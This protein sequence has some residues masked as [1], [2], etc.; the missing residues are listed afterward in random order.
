MGAP[1]PAGDRRRGPSG[2]LLRYAAR[3]KRKRR[4]LATALR[5]ATPALPR[6]PPPREP[7]FILGSPRSGTTS[8]FQLLNRSPRLASLDAESHLLW[9]AF[10]PDGRPGWTSHGLGSDSVTP[11]ERRFLHWAIDRLTLGRRYLDKDPR[12]SL[13]I[14]YLR[15]LFPDAWFV[16]LK[17]DGRAAVSSLITGWRAAGKQFPGTEMPMPLV[18][19]GYEGTTWRFAVP[20]GWEEYATGH[21]LAEVCAFQWVRT[22]EAILSGMDQAGGERWVEL[23]YEGLVAAPRE[24]TQRVLTALGLPA[25]EEVLSYADSFDRHVTKAVT[26]PREGKW[27][28]ENPEEIERIL[29]LIAPTMERLGYPPPG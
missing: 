25:D 26:A 12:N 16:H 11:A 22:N 1:S 3:S 4:A 29:P 18:I 5:V 23:T 2:L 24:E 9:E 17:R 28:E 10:H 19:D 21:S 8:L 13:R 20:P 6:R 15:A 27:R 14:R 7:I